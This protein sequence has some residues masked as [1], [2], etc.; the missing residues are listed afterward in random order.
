[1]PEVIAPGWLAQFSDFHWQRPLW[2]VLVPLALLAGWYLLRSHSRQNNWRSLID[3]QLLPHL[4]QG[5]MSKQQRLPFVALSLALLIAALAMAGPSWEKLPQPVFKTDS[6]LVILLDLS[7]SMLAQDVQPSRLVRARLKLIDLLQQRQEGLSALV[8]YAGEAHTVTPL[9]DDTE[10]IISLLPSLSPGIMPL[11]GSNTEMALEQALTLFRDSGHLQGDILLV[12]DGVEPAAA[13]YLL[14]NL[15]SGFRL[16][17]LGVGTEAGA[18]IPIS[19]GGFA[20]DNNGAIVLAKLNV[21]QLRNLASRAGGVYRNL[22]HTDSDVAALLQLPALGS[23]NTRQLERDFD[24][25]IDRGAWLCLLLLPFMGMAFRKGWLLLVPLLL[26]LPEPSQAFG[27]DDLWYTRDQ[28]GQRLLQQDQP[29]QA[30]GLF[31]REDWKGA[32]AYRAGDYAAAADAFAALDSASAHY[33]RGNALA[34]AGKLEDALKAY[35]QALAQEP[36]FEDARANRELVESLLQQQQ[37]QQQDGDQ[38]DQQQGDQ[39][40]DDQQQD[41]QQPGDQQQDGQQQDGQQQDGQQ[42]DSQGQGQQEPGA[43]D[44]SGESTPDTDP[45]QNTSEPDTSPGNSDEKAEDQ[46]TDTA[47]QQEPESDGTAQAES[48]AGANEKEQAQAAAAQAND[49]SEEEQQAMEQWLRKINDDPSGLMRK[50]FEHQYRQRVKQYQQG[51]WQPPEN[52]ANGRW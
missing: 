31:Q 28:Q 41:S 14:D 6:A 33:N 20:K 42:Q 23:D 32:A 49:L 3:A 24:T 4:L 34:R 11:R 27:W 2:L 1:M 22:S 5:K 45:E 18:P 36:D 10:T 29:E 46:A 48:E 21:E 8:V 35:D 16:S 52:G 37:Q 25:W 38:G 50:K 51:S 39:Q 19:S 44:R 15:P 7:P 40:Q 30:A 17:I 26:V 43:L 12:T 47:A 9:T 13:R